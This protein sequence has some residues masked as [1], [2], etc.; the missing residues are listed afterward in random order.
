MVDA[1]P[2][3]ADILIGVALDVRSKPHGHV[4]A[5]DFIFKTIG[6]HLL[7]ANQ[8]EQL[9]VIREEL[10]QLEQDHLIDV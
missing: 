5:A 4:A 2:R 7:E 9:N 3:I 10:Q 6:T 8:Q 1:T